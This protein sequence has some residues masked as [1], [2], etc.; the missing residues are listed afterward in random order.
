[1]N[2]GTKRNQ[3]PKSK[4]KSKVKTIKDRVQERNDALKKMQH[5]IRGK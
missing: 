5:R 3:K 2:F 1:M 4:P